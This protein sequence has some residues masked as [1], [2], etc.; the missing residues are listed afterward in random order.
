MRSKLV[1]L[2]HVEIPNYLYLNNGDYTFSNIT[3]SSGIKQNS[4]S[5]GAAYVDLDNDGDLDLVVNNINK[6]AFILINNEVQQGKP[7]TNHSISFILKGDSLNR[8]G[9]GAKVFVY[10]NGKGQLQE[11]YPVRGY[12]SSVDTKLLFGTGKNTK[13]DSVVIVWPNDKKQVLQNLV[14]D[15]AYTVY[16]KNATQQWQPSIQNNTQKT[17]TDVTTSVDAVYKHTDVAFNDYAEQRLLPQKFSQLGPFIST[18]DINKDGLEDF[19]IGGAFNFSGEAFHAIGQR[20]IHIKK[21]LTDSIKFQEDESS[22]L[23]DADGDGDLDLLITYGDTRYSDTSVFYHPRLYLNDGKGNFTLSANAIPSNVRTIAGC[24]AVADYDGDGDMD[25]FIG[26]RVSKQYPLSPHSY[27][28][29]N[30]KGIFTDV[31]NNV[32]PAL[33]KAGMITAAQWAD[34]DNDKHPDLIIAGEYMPIRFFKNNGST[35][36]EITASTGLQNMNGLWRSLIATDV[37]GDGDIDFIAGNLGLNCNY[38][39][40]HKYPMKLYAEDIDNNGKD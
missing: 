10:N 30:N 2:K 34:I 40:Q 33:S 12:L 17:F 37:D 35:F 27:L 13:A 20:K 38:H 8:N 28:L 11:E 23:F 16:Q 22:V 24:V 6:E 39:A 3:D 18:G 5:N 7:K 26:G 4:M 32:C 36:T 19:Y 15:T 31:T 21:D 14:A 9:F 29:Q 1:A 25:I